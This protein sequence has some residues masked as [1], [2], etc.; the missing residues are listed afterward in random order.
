MSP[1]SICRWT[2]SPIR[3]RR[4]DDTPTSSGFPTATEAAG[5]RTDWNARN[6]RNATVA[7]TTRSEGLIAGEIFM[8]AIL[9]PRRRPVKVLL[10][11]TPQPLPRLLRRVVRLLDVERRVVRLVS[12]RA[13][14]R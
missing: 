12:E 2:I 9:G 5:T 8:G 7:P 4:A 14:F 10:P 3:L 13:T 1:A 6:A 11:T